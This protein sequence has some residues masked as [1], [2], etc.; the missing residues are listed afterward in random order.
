[1][2]ALALGLAAACSPGGAEESGKDTPPAGA[3][4]A[5]P[6]DLDGLAAKIGCQAIT[7]RRNVQD[8]RQGTC[9][10]PQGRFTMVTFGSDQGRDAWLKEATKWGGAYLVG[11]RF[12]VVGTPTTLAPVKVKVGGDLR[13]GDS[14]HN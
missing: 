6:A 7:G 12:A 1:M 10:T 4:A 3:P 8:L 14:H 5:A 9:R 13:M 11:S 2:A